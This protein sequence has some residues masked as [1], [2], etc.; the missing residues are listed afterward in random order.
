MLAEAQSK[1]NEYT[2]AGQRDRA[3][4]GAMTPYERERQQIIQEGRDLLRQIPTT[5]SKTVGGT[6]A[7]GV[8]QGKLDTGTGDLIAEAVKRGMEPTE[9]NFQ[10]LIDE[11]VGSGKFRGRMVRMD[12]GLATSTI[13]VP[14]INRGAME[15]QVRGETAAR[16]ENFAE[17]QQTSFF[18][19][20]NQDLEAQNRLLDAN[21]E[22]FG[23][24]TEEVARAQK[25]AELLNQAKQQGLPLTTAMTAKIAAEAAAYGDLAKRTEEAAKKQQEFIVALNTVRSTTKDIGESLVNAF[26]RGE[27]AIESLRGVLDRLISRLVDN[28]LNSAI[29]GLFGKMGSAQTG[30]GGG[31][32]GSLLGGVGKLFGFADG[33]IMT[34]AGMVPLHAYA[35]GGVASGPQMALFGEG[36]RPEAY[37]PLPDG[38]NI[39]VKMQGQ[40]QGGGKVTINNYAGAD[41]QATRMS[42]GELFVV[43]NKMVDQK[44][45]AEVPGILANSQRRSM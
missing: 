8:A 42:D 37:V 41:V 6:G 17:I 18:F 9:T 23:K 43:I 15:G 1:I 40:Q 34:S 13:N 45:K 38:R 5:I 44:M 30:S 24:S 19:K 28:T 39:P 14:N 31:F 16:L 20:V 26:R 33:G 7:A 29:D 22:S 35:G 11:G 2:R 27:S 25:A 12:D 32:F 4:S 3:I 10:K 36:R 21:T